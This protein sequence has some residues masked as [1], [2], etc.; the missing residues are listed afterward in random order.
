MDVNSNKA[1]IGTIYDNDIIEK[2]DVHVKKV[3]NIIDYN[4][5]SQ[6]ILISN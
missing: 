2:I 4:E 3:I 5:N 1:I 6:S